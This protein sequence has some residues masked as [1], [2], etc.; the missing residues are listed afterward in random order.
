MKGTS[1]PRRSYIELIVDK[2]PYLVFS[3][4]SHFFALSLKENFSSWTDHNLPRDLS[5][6]NPAL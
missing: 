1:I 4:P 2:I 5:I 6:G 3:L